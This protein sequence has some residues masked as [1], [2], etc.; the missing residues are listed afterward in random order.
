MSIDP[1]VSPNSFDPTAA[2]AP[3]DVINRG[4]RLGT[5]A[6]VISGF[7]AAA[8]TLGMLDNIFNP[9]LLAVWPLRDETSQKGVNLLL[10]GHDHQGPLRTEWLNLYGYRPSV[11]PTEE[12]RGNDSAAAANALLFEHDRFAAPQVADTPADHIGAELAYAGHVATSIAMQYRAGVDVSAEGAALLAFVND[13]LGPLGAAVTAE[14][15][16]SAETLTYQAI[17]LLTQGYLHELT[18]FAEFVAE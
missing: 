17:A 11:P 6:S 1:A 12:A 3:E 5:A 15:Q 13:H 16:E 2:P 7:Y 8:P 9:D 14:T 10:S 4:V 18:S